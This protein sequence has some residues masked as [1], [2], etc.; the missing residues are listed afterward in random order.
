MNI[1]QIPYYCVIMRGGT[2]KGIF[3]HENDLPQDQALRDKVILSIFGSP[4][5][6]QIDGLGGA[7]PLTSKLAIIGPPSRPDA[8]VDYTFGQVEIKFAKIHY[9]GL[10]GNISSAV[11][12]FA[13]EEGLVRAVEPI[14]K[15]RV[16]NKNTNQ[17]F[18]I[19]VPVFDGKPVV[20]GDYKM[21][22]VPGTGAHLKLDMAG[23]VG[24]VTGKLLPTGNAKD[25]IK[26]DGMGEIT[27]S[28]IDMVNPCV[29]VNAEDLGLKGDEGPNDI[30]DN[31][32]LLENVEKIRSIVAKI[33]G[34]KDW[35]KAE[36]KDPIP[37]LVFVA[38]TRDYTNHLTKETIKANDVD[39]L[40]RLMFLGGM[41]QTYSGSI[42]CAT[43]TAAVVPGTVV[44]D[45]ATIKKGQKVVRL[46]H[47]AGIIEVDAECEEVAG[48]GFTM[49]RVTYSRTARR[50]MDG[51]VYV[52]KDVLNMEG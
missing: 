48:S 7:E 23:T 24:S 16:H 1:E 9:S 13:I 47:P 43:G 41:H 3:L 12:T 39:F 26:V 42:S 49:K 5:S 2:S 20:L 17:I 19:E 22:G 15:V 18:I 33:I 11:G 28:I 35:D 44:N 10:C 52:R 25:K 32:K 6:R 51:Y 8:D 36:V 31:V 30:K 27:V 34:L 50:I 45:V 21:D 40:T 14:T 4:D 37:F 29:F 38:S 46:G